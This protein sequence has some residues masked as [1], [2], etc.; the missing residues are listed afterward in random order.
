MARLKFYG[1]RL[2]VGSVGSRQVPS[3][4]ANKQASPPIRTDRWCRNGRNPDAHF[5]NALNEA[6]NQAA[7]YRSR[8][9]FSMIGRVGTG[10]GVA[11]L[12]STAGT[13]ERWRGAFHSGP[14]THGL[15][16]QI[17]MVAPDAGANNTNNTYSKLTVFTDATESTT[18]STTEFSYG[19][20]PQGTTDVYGVNYLK[21]ITKYIEVSPD[22]DY[23]LKFTDETYGRLLSASILEMPSMTENFD[24][25]L[26]QNN[27]S[28]TPV[29]DVM[30]ENLATLTRDLWKRAGARLISFTVD[31]QSSPK[32]NATTTFKNIVDGT[33]T[34]PSSS[35]PGYTLDMTN[36]T[37]LSQTTIPCVMKV[38]G[39]WLDA[40]SVGS[41]GTV[42]LVDSSNTVVATV[43]AGAGWS[44]TTPTWISVNV[45]MPAVSDKYDLQFRIGSAGQTAGT[46]SLYAI[47]IE[48]YES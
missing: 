10:L 14:M 4:P 31:D 2:D 3:N 45:N 43:G 8:E 44:S 12:S 1:D 13:R 34:T 6:A 33:S 30:R 22:T 28:Q 47:S 24:G 7:L 37:R 16:A 46:L 25:F 35:T 5:M 48:E 42:Q 15:Y 39:S 32:T 40:G 26:G 29:L 17:V 20:G 9:A 27:S 38:C 18:L 19:A 21:T 11:M 41:G 36:R 23:Y